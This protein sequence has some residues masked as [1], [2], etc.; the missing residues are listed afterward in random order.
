MVEP[1][2]VVYD[3]PDVL[4]DL[5]RDIIEE[6]SEVEAGALLGKSTPDLG[7]VAALKLP[8]ASWRSSIL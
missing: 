1:I 7:S 6:T 8:A 5:A 3:V 4:P 2:D